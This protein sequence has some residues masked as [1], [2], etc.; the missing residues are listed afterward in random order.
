MSLTTE[1]H[2]P[3]HN[4]V[5]INITFGYLRLYHHAVGIMIWPRSISALA[6][7]TKSPPK[8]SDGTFK[9]AIAVPPPIAAV[10]AQVRV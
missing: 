1:P 8:T 5:L 6:A 2:H 4:L 7:M 10:K 3:C 9:G